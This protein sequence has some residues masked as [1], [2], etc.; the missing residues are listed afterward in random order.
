M[1]EILEQSNL[2]LLK[3]IR[4]LKSLSENIQII[5]EMALYHRWV[6][7]QVSHLEDE[8]L[9]NLDYL[10]FRKRELHEVILNRTQQV[11]RRFQLLNSQVVGPLIRSLPTDKLCLKIIQWLHHQHPQTRDIPAGLADGEFGV[12]PAINFPIIY[13]MPISAQRG[14]LYLALFFHEFGHLLYAC[15]KPEMDELVKE[16]QRQMAALLKE[17]LYSRGAEGITPEAQR[18]ILET[19]Y[20]WTQEIFCD[21]VG[22]SIGGPGFMKTFSL[23]LR[24]V[25][26][27]AFH[28]P[29]ANLVGRSHPVT[30][31]RVRILCDRAKRLGLAAEAAS[32]AYEWKSIAAVMRVKEDYHGFY[33]KKFLP[34]IRH[35]IDD[36]LTEAAPYRF[37]EADLTSGDFHPGSSN[38]VQL[39]NA[40]W[41]RFLKDPGEYPEW[42]QQ[43]IAS[44]LS[45]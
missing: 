29:F 32:L 38:P 1:Q 17:A 37:H 3:E 20:E 35:T 7:T 18:C 10:Q 41:N 33:E 26:R 30:W 39:L 27:S 8:I 45:S 5:Q 40:A 14:L 21:A 19:W 12:W 9:K 28:L 25:G 6:I 23:Y 42:E 44:Y 11:N 4:R 13:Y 2:D 43:A 34:I 36:M 22:L 15:H 31:I 24:M 16:L